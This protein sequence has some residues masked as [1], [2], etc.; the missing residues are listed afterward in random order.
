MRVRHACWEHDVTLVFFYLCV[1]VGVHLSSRA[2]R[3]AGPGAPQFRGID[4]GVWVT[5]C[6]RA[7]R[8]SRRNAVNVQETVSV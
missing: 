5:A 2:R 7:G 3:D 1:L 4:V 6:L 8:R